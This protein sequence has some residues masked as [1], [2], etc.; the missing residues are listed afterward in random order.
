M[1]TVGASNI[2]QTGATLSAS[3]T[4]A[5]ALPA[6]VRFEYGTSSSAMSSTAYFNDGGLSY[7]SDSYSV[8]ISSL[9]PGTTYYYR[10]ALQVGTTDFYGEVKSFRTADAQQQSNVPAWL[11]LPAETSGTDFYAGYLGRGAS[12]NYSYLY[13]KSNYTAL[14]SAYPLTSDS[15]SAD[16]TTWNFNPDLPQNCQIN[17]KSSSYATN[18]GNSNYD[19]GHQVPAADRKQNS[20]VRSQVYWL[21]NQTPQLKGFNG[22]VWNSLENAVRGQATQT[23]TVYVVTGSTFRKVGGSETVKYLTSTSVTPE[24][25]PVPN[26]YWKVLLKVRRDSQNQI[27]AASAI[28][29]WFDHQT[30]ET[31][32][33]YSNFA[34]SVDEIERYTGFDFFV[35]L[36]DNL[37]SSCES[38]T[39]WT[40]FTDF[41]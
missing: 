25:V 36:P 29:F 3:Y 8:Q 17:V 34:V 19:R 7:P 1:T 23:D 35:N 30:Y 14:W 2:T 37:E 26:Y 20:T 21:T 13:D 18:Y 16:S 28:G 40:T 41:R 10:A 5:T 32:T 33:A 24:R 27:T 38:N 15:G 9:K 31:G 22:G 4:E 12:R 6:E 39:N 11:E